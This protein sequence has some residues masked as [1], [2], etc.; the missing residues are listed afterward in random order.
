MILSWPDVPAQTRRIGR[1]LDRRRRTMLL[2]IATV[3]VALLSLWFTGGEHLSHT[4]AIAIAAVTPLALAGSWILYLWAWSVR[5]VPASPSAWR[6][7]EDWIQSIF[8]A[9]VGA[10]L[11]VMSWSVV[12]MFLHA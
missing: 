12:G 1:K 4:R 8:I 6:R 10:A 9:V 5:S 2:S 11:V 7:A 3:W